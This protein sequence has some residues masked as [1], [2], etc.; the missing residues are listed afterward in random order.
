[1]QSII[2]VYNKTYHETKDLVSIPKS[3]GHDNT[4]LMIERYD[5]LYL[6]FLFQVFDINKGKFNYTPVLAS[7]CKPSDL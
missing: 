7:T 4:I 6:R 2:G 5:Q 1:M 3:I